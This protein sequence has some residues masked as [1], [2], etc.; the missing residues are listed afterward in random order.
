ME[1][2]NELGKSIN[3]IEHEF[4]DRGIQIVLISEGAGIGKMAH[5]YAMMKDSTKFACVDINTL[6]KIDQDK[7]NE[8]LSKDDGSIENMVETLISNILK[9][10]SKLREYEPDVFIETIKP[11]QEHRPRHKKLKG[12][13]KQNKKRK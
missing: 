11:Y 10:A 5:T 13:Q 2:K 3:A 9:D 6:P 7:L 12:W 1:Y 8:V 4:A